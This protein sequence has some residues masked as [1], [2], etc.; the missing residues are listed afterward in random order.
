MSMD[1]AAFRLRVRTPLHPLA[2]SP[3]F[4]HRHFFILDIMHMVDCS[5]V[6]GLVYG[7]VLH[8]LLGDIRL[9]ASRA[10]RLRAIDTDRLAH[11]S[12]RPGVP[13]LPKIWW[14][15]VLLDGW[16]NLHEQIFKAAIMRSAAPFFSE[17]VHRYFTS[18]SVEDVC[19]RGVVA[20]LVEMYDI[21]WSGPRFLLP[22]AMVQLRACCSNFGVFY[23]RLRALARRSN[24]LSWPVRPKVHKLMHIP[25]TAACINPRHCQCYVEESVVGTVAQTWKKSVAGRYERTVQRTVLAKR[26]TALL[27]RFE[28]GEDF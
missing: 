8:S 7:G 1:F 25:E 20:S 14:K 15:N 27:L 6:A 26:L 23:G 16:A 12:A 11:Y 3:L 18:D 5:G 21:L 17:L 13:R 19:L 4:C 22:P 28:L 2:S 9:G 10:A 24:T